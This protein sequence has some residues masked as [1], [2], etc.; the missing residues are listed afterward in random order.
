MTR[1]PRSGWRGLF[2]HC[3]QLSSSTS[4]YK[5]SEKKVGF[6]GRLAFGSVHLLWLICSIELLNIRGWDVG[7]M[8]LSLLNAYEKPQCSGLWFPEKLLFFL[9][10][11]KDG[12]FCF[13]RL[14]LRRDFSLVRTIFTAALKPTD[15][16]LTVFPPGWQTL[17]GA[18]QALVILR[19]HD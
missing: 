18:V 6:R 14:S 3:L 16:W 7:C 1:I 17:S 15:L 2:I 13:F 11:G 10:A 4:R 5:K 8:V 19:R 12:G 9:L